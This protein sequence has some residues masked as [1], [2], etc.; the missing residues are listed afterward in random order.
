M[1]PGAGP[2]AGRGRGARGGSGR[3]A[4][5]GRGGG[6]ALEGGFAGQLGRRAPGVAHRPRT[7]G[8]AE[9]AQGARGHRGC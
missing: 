4:E 3:W 6:R 9:S 5:P 8:P 1:A 2:W 7:P